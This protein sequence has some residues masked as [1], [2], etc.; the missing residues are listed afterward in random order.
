[1]TYIVPVN[2]TADG[3]SITLP[4]EIVENLGLKEGDSL[5]VVETDAG[6][7]LTLL[8]PELQGSVEAFKALNAKY[9]SVLRELE[10]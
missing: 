10:E 2:R 9:S 6:V 8:D 5:Y 1:M 3:L 4:P 7:L